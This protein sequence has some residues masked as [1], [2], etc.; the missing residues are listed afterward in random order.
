ME[1]GA[2]I[3]HADYARAERFLPW[4]VEPLIYHA[5]LTPH[6]IAG[7]PRF[8]Y[9]IRTRA[10]WRFMFVDPVANAQRI[11]FDHK[12]LAA[13]LASATGRAIDPNALPFAEVEFNGDLS[14]VAFELSGQR[15]RCELATYTC[16]SAH[17]PRP[18]RGEL[19]SPDGRWVAF[20][21]DYNLW[22]RCLACG[23][24]RALTR[25]GVRDKDYAGPTDVTEGVTG[26]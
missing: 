3:T 18:G 12:R 20:L 2:A 17:A 6:W 7:G 21:R 1:P 26:V 19:L 10:G 8:W 14:T 11:G 25:D 23:E 15:W 9:R 16:E 22:V 5:G 4:N 24:E 13:A